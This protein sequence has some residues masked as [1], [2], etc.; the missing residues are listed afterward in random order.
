M[1]E[2]ALPIRFGIA[3]SG[4]LIA[5]FLLLSLFGLHTNVL[6]SLFNG[7]ITGFG[8]YESIKYFR[9]KKGVAFNYGIGFTAGI[10]TGA[11]ATIIFTFFFAFYSTEINTQFLKELS[12]VWFS[13]YDTLEGS[14]FFTVATMGF[15]TTL[16]LTLAFMQLFKTS[17]NLNQKSA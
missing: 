13:D 12:R 1:K 16:V 9:I 6:Y 4:S 10:V 3:T 15:A 7:V 14:I 11:I 8:I 5:Y 2:F 17:K